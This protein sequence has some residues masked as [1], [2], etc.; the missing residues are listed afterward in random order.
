MTALFKACQGE[1]LEDRRDRAILTFL[2]DTGARRGA[3]TNLTLDDVDQEQQLITV[4]EKGNCVRHLRYGD[5]AA[6]VLS[7][8]L[9][10]RRKHP[11]TSGQ[12]SGLARGAG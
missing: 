6:Q 3:I 7:R 10:H 11:F 1:R 12:S 5:A 4:T 8:Y 9:H 2:Y